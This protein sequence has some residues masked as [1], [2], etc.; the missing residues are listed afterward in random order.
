MQNDTNSNHLFINTTHI[1]G[2]HSASQTRMKRRTRNHFSHD[3]KC[4]Y[5]A[6]ELIKV[7]EEM[8]QQNKQRAR[9]ESAATS[10]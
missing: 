8:Q 5:A 1:H 4:I 6:L 7:E 3:P 10:T 2:Y 9:S